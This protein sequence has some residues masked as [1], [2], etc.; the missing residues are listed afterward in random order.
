MRM[1]ALARFPVWSMVRGERSP[2][3]RHRL[4]LLASVKVSVAL[5]TVMGGTKMPVSLSAAFTSPAEFTLCTDVVLLR[6]SRVT[7]HAM[8]AAAR[9]V[10]QPLQTRLQ[11]PLHPRVAKTTADAD[12]GGN[13][14]NGH[15]ISEE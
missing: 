1:R 13:L 2:E 3:Q 15:P 8:R 7:W 11:K 5:P 12:R 14:G 9:F 6:Q 4:S 10:R